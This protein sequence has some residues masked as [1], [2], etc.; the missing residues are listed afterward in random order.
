MANT[1][2]KSWVQLMMSLNIEDD[3]LYGYLIEMKKNKKN[4]FFQEL[5]DVGDIDQLIWTPAKQQAVI[6]KS[7]EQV[8][9]FKYHFI[10]PRKASIVRITYD[11]HFLM[12]G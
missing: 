9:E 11:M 6:F 1:A 12:G 10:N 5:V 7:E 3:S 8:E 4:W 2:Y